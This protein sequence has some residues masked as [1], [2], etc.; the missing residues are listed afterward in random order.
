MNN[1]ENRK[2]VPFANQY[3]AFARSF[4]FLANIRLIVLSCGFLFFLSFVRTF[5]RSFFVQVYVRS[6]NSLFVRSII[7]SFDPSLIRSGCLKRSKQASHYL[8]TKHSTRKSG[9]CITNIIYQT[10]STHVAYQ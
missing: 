3:L 5:F 8:N 6:F 4:I 2:F 9:L 10:K 7:R 1:Q